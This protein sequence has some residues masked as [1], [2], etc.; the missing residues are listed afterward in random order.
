MTVKEL[1]LRKHNGQMK[2]VTG[3]AGRF[4]SLPAVFNQHAGVT[5]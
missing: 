5:D 2:R 3:I 4:I 1:T